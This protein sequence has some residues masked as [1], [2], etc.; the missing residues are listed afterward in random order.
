MLT[1]PKSAVERFRHRNLALRYGQA[2]HQHM[3][4]EKVV[5]ADKAFCDKLYNADEAIARAMIASRIDH[6]N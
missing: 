2:F 5:G 6:V 3:K 4:L 1:F